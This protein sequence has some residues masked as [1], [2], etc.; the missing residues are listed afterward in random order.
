M[1]Y[2]DTSVIVA[3]L[4]NEPK[5]QNCIDWFG[6]LKQTPVSGDWLITEFNSAIALKQRTGQLQAKHIKPILQQ[7]EAL[8]NGGIKLLPVSRDAFSQAGK[9]TL[10]HSNTRAG[11]ALHLSVALECE[12]KDFV[13]L[14]NTQAETAKQLKFNV[15]LL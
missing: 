2:V 3:M 13:T 9:L 6:C 14:D 5:T 11:D 1:V 4:T 12:T 15:T 7:F 8:I 10:T